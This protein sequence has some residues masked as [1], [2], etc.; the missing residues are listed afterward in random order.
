MGGVRAAKLD[1]V[2]H[3]VVEE[4]HRLK[5][6]GDVLHQAVQLVLPHI[7]AAYG[8]PAALDIP[9]A[10]DEIAQSGLSAA[11]GPHHGGGAAG[12][13]GKTHMIQNG[14]LPI[15]ERDILKPDRGIL[16][17]EFRPVNIHHRRIVDGVGLIHGGAQHLEIIR[18]IAGALQ[19][20]I[21]HERGYEHQQAPGQ[22]Q[23]PTGIERQSAYGQRHGKQPHRNLP[24]A[25]PWGYGV[26]QS[27]SLFTAF[28]HSFLH[29]LAAVFVQS[30]GLDHTH[31]LDVLQHCLHQLH[32][33]VLA[34]RP[35]LEQGPLAQLR[36]QQI[37]QDAR[38]S[39]QTEPPV[40]KQDRQ[41]HG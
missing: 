21:E 26:L 27:Q 1:I 23:A 33:G 32:L 35:G 31:T 30:I 14:P 22:G 25:H 39:Q 28:I 9:K 29:G 13:D 2:L 16:R 10:G 19:L 6:H 4:I 36:N 37:G 7:M 18:H 12:G 3:R 11:G 15:G 8:D 17:L 38:D 20:R 34:G 24:Q 40:H 41:T 5:H